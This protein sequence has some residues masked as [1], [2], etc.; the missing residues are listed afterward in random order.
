MSDNS[1]DSHLTLTLRQLLLFLHYGVLVSHFY[2]IFE[3]FAHTSLL[4]SADLRPVPTS[5]TCPAL[6]LLFEIIN[7]EHLRNT[8]PMEAPRC[9]TKYAGNTIPVLQEVKHDTTVLSAVS[10]SPKIREEFSGVIPVLDLSKAVLNRIFIKH[11]PCD[12]SF[13]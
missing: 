2:I 6:D 11:Q 5:Y 13:H 7:V 10:S 12:I 8:L 9:R 1:H 4:M 3:T